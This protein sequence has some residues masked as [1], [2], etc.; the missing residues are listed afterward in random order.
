MARH[1]ALTTDAP[2][3]KS[4]AGTSLLRMSVDTQQRG[5]VIDKRS[6]LAIRF[7]GNRQTKNE[8]GHTAV[9]WGADLCRPL[10][11]TI[12]SRDRSDLICF[13]TRKTIRGYAG[14]AMRPRALKTRGAAEAGG[15]AGEKAGRMLTNPTPDSVTINRA[16]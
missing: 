5:D 7:A 11:S 9:S 8:R 13:G 2:T 14:A 6:L 12:S 16:G 3:A 1:D 4:K 15:P 10:R